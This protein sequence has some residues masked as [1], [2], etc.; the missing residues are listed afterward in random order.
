MWSNH[1]KSAYNIVSLT[2]STEQPFILNTA[3]SLGLVRISCLSNVWWL[4]SWQG[5]GPSAMARTSSPTIRRCPE[6]PFFTHG[7]TVTRMDVCWAVLY[8]IDSQQNATPYFE[9]CVRLQNADVPRTHS[10]AV[11]QGT[12]SW[13]PQIPVQHLTFLL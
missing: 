1:C 7:V 4:R 6:A 9:V 8:C 2:N 3:E 13:A 11:G 12:M 5:S 10:H